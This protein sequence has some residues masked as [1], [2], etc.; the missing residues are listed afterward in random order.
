VTIAER[1]KRR[2]ERQIEGNGG[3]LARPTVPPRRTALNP[4]KNPLT[5][6]KTAGHI[7]DRTDVRK[8]RT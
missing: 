8:S 6:R 1:Q 5:K 7:P 4:R 3:I 2:L